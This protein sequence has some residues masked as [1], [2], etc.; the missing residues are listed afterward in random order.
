MHTVKY[1]FL[2]VAFLLASCGNDDEAP[3]AVEGCRNQAFFDGQGPRQF[4]MGFSTWPYA[5]TSESV[6]GT[7]EFIAAHADIYS[8]HIDNSIPWN[9][10]MNG[11]PL[12]EAF[13][14]E[15]D[16]KVART[17]PQMRLALSVSLLNTDRSDLASDFDGSTPTYTVLNDQAIEDTY[18][19]HI[20]YLTDRLEPDYLVI[21]I[22]VNELRINAPSKWNAY[23][24]LMQ[25]V[26]SRIQAEY[27]SLHISESLTLHNLYQPDVPDPEAYL[28]E[29]LAYANAMD[30]VAISFYPFF[31]GLH[32]K[33]DFQLAFDFLHA[34]IEPPIAFA[35]TAHLA[36]DLDVGSF[37]L[38]IESNPCEQN[39]YM[40]SLLL[41]AAQQQYEYVIWWAHRDFY[42][43]WNTFPDPLKDLGKLWR[44]T[45]LLEDDGTGR[46]GF[47]TWEMVFL[48]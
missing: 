35:E 21:A 1:I 14:N 15:I 38:Y 20:D 17:I 23:K 48:E 28:A 9:A 31:K 22:E 19:Q 36:E 27:P 47:D 26:K 25:N 16:G 8:E 39:A 13:T 40:E 30:F 34:H 12:P 46:E 37:N 32:T 5:P 42:E 29:M 41:N 2:A 3:P 44:N 10:W 6:S 45:G 18:F 11:L 7:Y 43:L 4:E 24:L 33:A